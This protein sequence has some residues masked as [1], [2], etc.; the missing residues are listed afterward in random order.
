MF[1]DKL[2]KVNTELS[3][4]EYR[5]KDLNTKKNQNELK[6]EQC[7]RDVKELT[8]KINSEEKALLSETQLAEKNR[9]EN[10]KL[11]KEKEALLSKIR[12]EEKM[13]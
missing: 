9:V 11:V 10:A 6:I 13:R 7:Q 8:D 12:E 4:L 2:K 5:L 1:D 3:Q